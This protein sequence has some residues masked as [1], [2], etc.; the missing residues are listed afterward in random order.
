M[1]HHSLQMAKE[2]SVSVFCREEGGGNC[3]HCLSLPAHYKCGWCAPLK[4]CTTQNQCEVSII[5]HVKDV[6]SMPFLG[7][8][9]MSQTRQHPVFFTWK[10]ENACTTTYAPHTHLVWNTTV[11]N[12]FYVKQ[13]EKR[14]SLNTQKVIMLISP[15]YH[16]FSPACC[17]FWGGNRFAFLFWLQITQFK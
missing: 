16:P 11:W 6:A 9:D 2:E 12:V 10:Y 1:L 14:N 13:G 3:G 17:L 5:K 4:V 7:K 8:I 15:F